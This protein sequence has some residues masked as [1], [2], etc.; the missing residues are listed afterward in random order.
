MKNRIFIVTACVALCLLAGCKKKG[1]D[2]EPDSFYGSA[3]AP[4]WSVSDS[5]DYS[6]SMTAI[7]AVDLGAQY[8][9]KASD[10]VLSSDDVVAAFIQGVCVGVASPIEGL[11]F[12]YI[13]GGTAGDV[14]L[15]YYSSFYKRQFG[16]DN[17]F[18]FENDAMI[19]THESPFLPEWKPVK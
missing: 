13:A 1:S 12:L 18:T 17:A 11:F 15:R 16:A 19:G 5:Y 4:S 9:D 14:S 8:P 6:S 7:I 2:K 3:S 10:F